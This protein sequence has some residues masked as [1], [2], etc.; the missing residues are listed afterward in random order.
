MSDEELSISDATLIARL[1]SNIFGTGTTMLAADR[2]EQLVKDNRELV[3][4]S[5]ADTGQAQEAYE[6]Q[7]KAEARAEQLAATNERLEAA[8]KEAERGL[9]WA[10]EHLRDKGLT[11]MNVDAA[12]AETRAALKGD[13]HE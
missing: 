2:I 8:L 13:D 10:R 9:F 4:Q 12:L 7:L 3:M 5:L 11:S 6:A 1:R